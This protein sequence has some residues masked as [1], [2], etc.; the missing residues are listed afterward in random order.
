MNKVR[1]LHVMLNVVMLKSFEKLLHSLLL[2]DIERQRM[3]SNFSRYTGYVFKTSL[4][5]FLFVED[6][7]ILF[8]T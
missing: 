7:F 2:Q 4:I 8:V 1:V 3:L 6:E 5:A